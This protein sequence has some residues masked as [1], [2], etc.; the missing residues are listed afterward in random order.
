MDDTP[1]DALIAAARR[2]ADAAR[3]VTLAHFRDPGLAT[4]DK[5]ATGFDPVT[6]ADREAEAAIREVLSRDRPDDAILG[7]EMAGREG[8]SGFTWVIDPIDGTRGYISGTPTWGTLISVRDAGGPLFGLIDQPYTDERFLGGF[9]LAR[10]EGPRGA[11]DLAVRRGRGLSEATL[12][13][14]FPEVGS[15][16]EA[17][18]F[19]R[20]GARVRLVRYGMDC[21]AY[22]L[23]ALG[24]IDLVVEAGLQAYDIQAPIC[25]VRA[26]GGIVT[27][28]QG[29]DPS[30]GGRVVAAG[31]AELHAAALELLSACPDG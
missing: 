10:L 13:T 24:Q 2:A 23:L 27:D 5:G 9:G 21:Y 12:M 18:A 25:V 31:S 29:G 1:T 6:R 28:W 30:G 17:R 8:G 11:R 3:P 14:T 7:E 4:D 19:H 22:A 26:A 16:A 15:A 20:L